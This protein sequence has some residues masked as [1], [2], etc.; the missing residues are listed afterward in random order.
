MLCEICGKD[1][2]C[3][4]ILPIVKINGSLITIA[5]EE[6]AKASSA[7]CK[8]HDKINMGFDGGY[9]LCKDCI[10]EAVGEIGETVGAELLGQVDIKVY[11]W[12]QLAEYAEDVAAITCESKPRIIGRAIII[13]SMKAKVAPEEI[14]RQTID[15]GDPHLLLPPPMLC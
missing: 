5:C 6:C 13:A 1:P 3:F 15:I 4:Y 9:S 14:I 8:E 7:Y 12:E 2:E 11:P 10:D